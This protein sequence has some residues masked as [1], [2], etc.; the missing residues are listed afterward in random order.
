MTEE[1][2]PEIDVVRVDGLVR[3][4][5]DLRPDWHDLDPADV[6]LAGIGRQLIR[7]EAGQGEPGHALS[8]HLPGGRQF[9]V[10]EPGIEDGTVAGDRGETFLKGTRS[11]E[12]PPSLG[13]GALHVIGELG[14]TE[15]AAL[16]QIAHRVGTDL[17]LFG[18]G[19]SAVI[20]GLA[21]RPVA[22]RLGAGI[23]PP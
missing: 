8:P 11:N 15:R 5:R 19:M 1:V 21:L 13:P 18:L 4:G 3:Q 12:H 2:E 7:R 23:V 14:R 6:V 16:E 22:E 20:L 17:G 10:Q 9:Q